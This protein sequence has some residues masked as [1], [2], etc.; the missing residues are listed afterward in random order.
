[1]RVRVNENLHN[2]SQ[3][4]EIS[5]VLWLMVALA[6]PVVAHNKYAGA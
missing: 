5:G 6:A 4:D 2:M 1:L 3:Y